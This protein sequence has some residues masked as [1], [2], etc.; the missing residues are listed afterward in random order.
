MSESLASRPDTLAALIDS[1]QDLRERL[2]TNFNL[3][4]AVLLLRR[5]EQDAVERALDLA[6]AKPD[7]VIEI[8]AEC[9]RI[10]M[11]RTSGNAPEAVQRAESLAQKNRFDTLAALY[12]RLLF[13]LI[14]SAPAVEPVAAAPEADPVLE[15]AAAPAQ[16]DDS[17]SVPAEHSVVAE[18]KAEADAP[19]PEE[20]PTLPVKWRT[21]GKDP[22][23]EF[24]RIVEGTAQHEVRRGEIGVGVL[25][26]MAF[27]LAERILNRLSFGNLKHSSFEGANK[28]IHSWK[29]DDLRACAVIQS[30]SSASLLAARCT[31][32]FEDHT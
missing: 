3:A 8:V 12:Y 11:L 20:D 25:D 16:G 15:V 24:L 13:P 2:T 9:I 30:G 21:I 31:R 17:Q 32:A 4:H 14:D 22:A 29:R 26:E 7:P 6:L 1:R 28:V 19:E 23:V 18:H 27:G 5:G 10:E